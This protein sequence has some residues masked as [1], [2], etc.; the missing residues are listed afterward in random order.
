MC[1]FHMATTAGA[2]PLCRGPSRCAG[3]EVYGVRNAWPKA[4]LANV[5][6]HQP[7]S[8]SDTRITTSLQGST[9]QGHTV[10][11]STILGLPMWESH[12]HDGMIR[13]RKKKTERLK[14]TNTD[15]QRSR[16]SKSLA[17]KLRKQCQSW[18]QKKHSPPTSLS[19]FSLVLSVPIS[20]SCSL[21][22]S[23][24][25]RLVISE[26]HF[27]TRLKIYGSTIGVRNLV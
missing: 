21:R 5:N 19:S 6:A 18:K 10:S 17:T 12:P 26:L 16:T 14:D 8:W 4:S 22:S 9:R 25:R 15:T 11:R 13:Q 3:R 7:A 27:D 23:S 20:S 1:C 2:F 24:N